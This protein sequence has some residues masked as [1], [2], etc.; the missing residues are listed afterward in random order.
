MG[1]GFKR[2]EN[3]IKLRDLLIIGLA[4]GVSV[5]LALGTRYMLQ[6]SNGQ[7]V[8]MAKVLVASGELSVGTRL[9]ESNFAWK[10]WPADSIQQNYITEKQKDKV[11]E[12]VGAFVRDRINAGEPIIM[13]DLATEKSGILSAVVEKGM[14][15]F[16]IPVDRRT[17]ISGQLL[18]ED[19]VDVLV[20]FR[21]AGS[22]QY[23]ART[24]VRQ[25]K[26][27]EV[28]SELD[29]EKADAEAGDKTKIKSITVQVTPVQA[30][31]LAAGLRE[32]TPVI[33]LH[34]IEAGGLAEA[35]EEQAPQANQEKKPEEKK[36]SQESVTVIRG[37]KVEK[38]KVN[39]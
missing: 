28:N 15:G 10:D 4:L 16:T 5:A 20:S 9:V 27:L 1:S 12:L 38:L 22:R 23:K 21:D 34:S 35:R 24:I 31:A 17:S 37:D 7:A 11:K 25:V 39:P 2:V 14:V 3:M 18:P 26:V 19:R 8:K 13:G 6:G 33:S 36:E 29:P 32:G 30:E